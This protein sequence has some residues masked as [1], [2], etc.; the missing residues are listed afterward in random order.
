M[1]KEQIDHNNN[2]DQTK[3]AIHEDENANERRN[4]LAEKQKLKEV[5]VMQAKEIENLKSEI[6]LYK[7]KGG[8]IYTKVTTDRRV[9]NLA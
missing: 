3:Q 1:G 7:R 5:L 6:N 9:A 8:H 4:L 2:L